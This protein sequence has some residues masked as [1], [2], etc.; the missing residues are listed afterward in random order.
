MAV[1]E[2]DR[3]TRVADAR[4]VTRTPSSQIPEALSMLL[5]GLFD[6]VATLRTRA[7]LR[8]RDEV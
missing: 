7:D 5:I 1:T 2:V 3:N 4:G 8:V 6:A